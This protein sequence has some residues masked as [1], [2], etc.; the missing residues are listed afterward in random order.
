MSNAAD[1]IKQRDELNEKIDTALKSE[2]ATALSDVRAK[3]KLHK[4]TLTELRSVVKMRKRKPVVK[5][6]DAS[7]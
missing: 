1:L 3:I 2:R 7:S 4:F 5:V 6:E